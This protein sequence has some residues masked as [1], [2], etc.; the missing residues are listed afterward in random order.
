LSAHPS[1]VRSDLVPQAQHALHE[2]RSRLEAISQDLEP[3]PDDLA[4]TDM[5]L[6]RMQGQTNARINARASRAFHHEAVAR[7]DQ[8][9]DLPQG[10][11]YRPI[12]A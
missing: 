4:I 5:S 3:L 11:F 1:R 8:P 12:P 6:V 7:F 2:P 9:V 10:R